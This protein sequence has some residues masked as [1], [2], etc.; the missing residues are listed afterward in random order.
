M[1][2]AELHAILPNL[3]NIVQQKM[4]HSLLPDTLQKIITKAR[5]QS[6]ETGLQ[7][8][9]VN[10]FT[11]QKITSLDLPLAQLR[12]EQGSVLCADPCYLHADR[13]R[14]ILFSDDLDISNEEALQLIAAIQPLLDEFGASLQCNQ[15]QQWFISLEKMPEL[16]FTALADVSGN[17]V[18]GFLPTG[19]EQQRLNWL[20]LWN[21][22]Q[23][24]LFDFPLNTEREQQGKAPINSLWFWGQGD[25][26]LNSA[27]WQCVYG[28]DVLLNQ[29]A[30]RS[31][32]VNK[33]LSDINNASIMGRVLFVNEAID[34]EGDWSQQLQ[35]LE[36]QLT[37][38]WQ[39][40]KW[41]KIASLTIDI[42]HFGHYRMTTL[43][44]WKFW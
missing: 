31:H 37:A 20:R 9:L 16:N 15:Q 1:A 11:T 23:M 42:P 18:H 8:K 24:L 12:D 30:Q 27:A 13:D 40:V 22:I 29:L 25:L 41:G 2:K 5:F 32:I 17:S 44:C 19:D 43:D 35:Q 34:L 33:P 36:Q 3:A 21:E 38:W 14:L 7:R 6:D 10:L 4:N 39:L 28:D 26:A